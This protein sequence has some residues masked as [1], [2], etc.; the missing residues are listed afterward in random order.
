[1]AP[2]YVTRRLPRFSLMLSITAAKR[3]VAFA[4]REDQ[5]RVLGWAAR[6]VNSRT[7]IAAANGYME[8]TEIWALKELEEIAKHPERQVKDAA[9][10]AIALLHA[11]V[12]GSGPMSLAPMEKLIHSYATM[13]NALRFEKLRVSGKKTLLAGVGD[14]IDNIVYSQLKLR[15][16]FPHL[17]CRHCLARPETQ[18]F[19]EWEWVRCRHCK[20]VSGLVTGVEQVIGQ[21][22]G[23]EDWKLANGVLEVRIWDAWSRQARAAQIDSLMI[24]GGQEMDY[25]WAVGAVVQRLQNGR[26]VDDPPV[27]IKLV[28]GVRLEQNSML[29]LRSLNP[30][31]EG[32]GMGSM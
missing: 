4:S 32:E 14:K 18:R 10:E 28:K 31:F 30:A 21:I 3:L 27:V 12:L 9:N 2:A 24:I 17:F 29:L 15:E 22:G 19:R 16:G 11:A 5:E 6:S 8:T 1:M 26:E 7:V 25:D 13:E 20:D 23:E